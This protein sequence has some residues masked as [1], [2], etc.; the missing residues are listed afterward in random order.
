VVAA[1]ALVVSIVVAAIAAVVITGEL[2]PR[3]P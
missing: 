1:R 3:H 2:L